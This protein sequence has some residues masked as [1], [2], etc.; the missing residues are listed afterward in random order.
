MTNDTPIRM[1][2]YWVYRHWV[3]AG[4]DFWLVEFNDGWGEVRSA[5]S[6]LIHVP[7]ELMRL[8]KDADIRRTLRDQAPPNGG[9]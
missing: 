9:L 8:L 3:E 7:P 2:E 1:R 5:N 6:I 4:E